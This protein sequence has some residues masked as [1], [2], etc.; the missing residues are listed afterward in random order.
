MG[1]VGEHEDGFETAEG[2]CRGPVRPF[3]ASKINGYQQRRMNG[4][5]LPKLAWFG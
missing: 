1:A 4:S 3:V 5:S 2:Q